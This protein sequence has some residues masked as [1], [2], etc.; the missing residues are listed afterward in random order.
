MNIKDFTLF[1]VALG[2]TAEWQ[3]SDYN[4]DGD[5]GEL[6]IKLDFKK[7]SKFACASCGSENLPVHDTVIKR[8][9][10][11]NFF[12]HKAFLEARVPRSLCP[13][14]G[15]HLIQVPWS[16]P[17]S[18]FT[19]LFELH[20]LLLTKDMPVS[21]IASQLDE[22]DTRLWRMI[23]HYVD[24]ARKELDLSSVSRVGVDETSSKKGHKYVTIFVDLDSS[25][26]LF[27]TKGKDSDT[28]KEFKKF[29]EGEGV[30]PDAIT[31]FSSDMS[32]A[33]IS[34]VEEHFPK[35]RITFDKFHI[36]KKLNEAVDQVRREEVAAEEILKKTRYLWL[37][38]YENLTE[39]QKVALN[40][41]SF[42]KKNL[43][44]ARAYRIKLVFQELYQETAES[45]E[46]FL[47]KWY[48]WATHSRLEPIKKFAGT[49]KS[50]WEGI[51]SWF[52]TS[53]NN[54]VLEGIN[55]LIQNAKRR[56]RGF[57]NTDNLIT[58]IYLISG[59]FDWI[60]LTHFN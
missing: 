19:L 32:P 37:K 36:S 4:F 46:S 9:R 20:V 54:G 52:D 12:Q 13:K 7:G 56:A 5:S 33:F 2:L 44:T 39:K 1:S 27:A 48:F 38:N 16:R 23:R 24:H 26:V 40:K 10:H 57:R 49:V 43:K 21:A 30:D 14:C 29:L 3:V 50:H 25:K 59:K 22:H 58:M 11:L 8:W 45:A 34:G 53:I 28:I 18:G 31:D 42:A 6:L 17:G 60:S 15:V 55:S 41:V 35:A 47:K 51:L